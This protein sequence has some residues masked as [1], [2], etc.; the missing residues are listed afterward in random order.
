M[1]LAAHLGNCRYVGEIRL[2]YH[3]FVLLAVNFGTRWGK[4]RLGAT[5]GGYTNCNH[6]RTTAIR[7]VV[8]NKFLAN[9]LFN[10]TFGSSQTRVSPITDQFTSSGKRL[11]SEKTLD[12][13]KSPPRTPSNNGENP[14]KRKVTRNWR[15][16][17][18]M[19]AARG[20][21]KFSR[22]SPE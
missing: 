9:I 8:N 18:P 13:S 3:S 1:A 7:S 2:F 12:R 6:Y 15:H 11:I 5:H 21:G 19:R 10:D 14:V 22:Y 20:S 16:L 17:P 4:N